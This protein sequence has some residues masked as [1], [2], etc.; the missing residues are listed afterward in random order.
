MNRPDLL[1]VGAGFFGL[2][3]AEHAARELGKRVLVLERRDHI[4]GN[5]YDYVDH[6]T[7][8]NIHRF[9][10]HLFHTPHE[11]VWNYVN[12]FSE[13][14]PYEHRVFA[15]S[16]DQVYSFPMNLGLISQFFGKYLTPDEAKALIAEQASEFDPETATNLEEKA[17]SLIGRPLYEAFVKNYTAKQWETDP[18]ELDPGI[19]TR[20]PVRYTFDNRYF[21]DR[22]QGLPTNGYTALFQKMVDSPLIE[23]R[24]GVDY[25]KEREQWAGIPTVYTGPLDEYFGYSEGRLPWRTVDL[26]HEVVET[27][28]FQ[29]TAVMNY[30]DAE[31][32][33]TRI[34]E[35]KH[36]DPLASDR[37]IEG[38]TIITREY[39]RFAG[40][41]D[42]CYY[43]I[44]SEGSRELANH[45]RN[46]AK[47]EEAK[48]IY[49]GGRLA[50]YLYLDMFQ[51]IKGAF[52]LWEKKVKPQLSS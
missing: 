26:V 1:V 35:W 43:P 21:N 3:V 31:P 36:L 51:A 38:K 9:G 10:S 13:F 25:L 49:F 45:Y 7:N 32:R 12:R 52:H 37:K 33:F 50:G 40:E 47:Q 34:L 39:S 18:K 2:T 27:D 22:W 8:I 16:G 17:I 46:L 29:G 5:C 19:I 23:V 4:G 20:L 30:N 6:E 41:N 44:N 28:D 48:G 42:E 15:R 11:D 14:T 24:Y